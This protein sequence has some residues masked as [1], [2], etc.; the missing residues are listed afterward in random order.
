MPE[1]SASSPPRTRRTALVLLALLLALHGSSLAGPLA[2]GQGGNCAAMFALM[3]RNAQARGLLSTRAVPLLNPAP[4]APDDIVA[5]Y[6]H[7]PP[8]LPWLVMAAAQLPLAL[9]TAERL[10]ALAL[11][12]WSTLLLA[13]LARSL[14]D[15][16]AALA[17][18]LAWLLLPSGVLHGLLV[19]YETIA[20]PPMLGLTGALLI[21]RARAAR[22]AL[23]AALCDWISVLPAL[24]AGPVAGWRRALPALG[25][26][27]GMGL[28][29]L[30]HGRLLGG[31]TTGETLAQALAATFLGPDFDPAAWWTALL[32]DGGT[33][34]G[35][36]GP[37]ALLA[38]AHADGTRRAVL[39]LLLA[40]G[41]LNVGLFA[42]HASSHE[43]FWLLLA[44]FVA[45]GS[46]LLAFPHPRRGRGAGAL[47]LA[48]L[49]A[50]GWVFALDAPGSRGSTAQSERAAAFAQVADAHAVYVTPRGVALV[51]LA[52]AERLV[53]PYPVADA[54]TARA[55]ARRYAARFVRSARPAWVFVHRDDP[56]PPWLATLGPG[57]ARGAFLFWPLHD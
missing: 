7:H 3:T 1:P 56:L 54:A 8:G 29:V 49:L 40:C 38:F 41:L 14:A 34:F 25:A 28:A 47:V 4:P 17:T 23:L 50:G 27:V 33:L 19:N 22:W 48:A 57:E 32:R 2:D 31:G 46:A 42:H 35:L 55:A 18:G 30:A 39:A 52:G 15:E 45:L 10:V 20:V 5:P 51:F 26:A 12:A 6:T 9:E 37:A 21:R 43:H 44:P 24:L 13:G 11:F 53:L 16:R 36:A